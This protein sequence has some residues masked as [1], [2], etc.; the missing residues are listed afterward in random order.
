MSTNFIDEYLIKLGAAVD[1]SGM[2]RFHQALR[3][4]SAVAESSAASIAGAF[5]KAQTEV[6]S[7]LAA[8]G[9]A[10]LGLVDKVAMADQQYRLFALHMYMSKDA[11]RGL[12]VAMDALGEP[13]ENLAWDAELRA[14][15]HQL[16]LDQQAMAPNGDFD[17]QMRKIRDVRFEFTRMEVELQYLGMHV[18]QDF[19]KALGLGPDEL[20]AKLRGFNDWVTHHLPQISAT[21]VRDFMPVWKDLKD[22]FFAV[23]DALEATGTAFTNLV[24]LLTGDTAIEGSTFKLENFFKA[25]THI[26]H[27]FAVFAE[28]IANIEALLAHF[29]A[30]IVDVAAGNFSA[31]NAELAAAGADLRAKA[32]GAIVGGVTGGI[33][34]SSLGPLGTAG[35]AVGGAALGANIFDKA[36]GSPVNAASAGGA[37]SDLVSRYAAQY[38]VDPKLAHALMMQESSGN[39]SAVSS[40]GA[41][42]LMQL[43]RHTARALGVDRTNTDQNVEGGVRLFSQLL[44]KYHDPALAIAAYHDGEPRVDAFLARRATL[45][46]EALGEIAGVQ[47]RMN[48]GG[49]DVTVG[50]IVVH[51]DKPNAVN[52][53][54]GNA[55]AARLRG[56][57]DKRTQRNLSE[58][59][60]LSWG[61]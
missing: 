33:L 51:V 7:G 30:A 14:R 6:V 26:I 44:Q 39:P 3:E 55:V 12:K 56:L 10:A 41:V 49:G 59:Q 52:A 24:G 17:A 22:V 61:Y 34:G 42:G 60:G 13:L 48:A 38:G 37:A 31:A 40:T 32:V 47:R 9:G 28:A 53:D 1:A 36:F 23:K 19:M 8:I 46:S 5:F 35:G 50:S 58:F 2:A 11:A 16:I 18:V 27:G 29:T 45:S 4:A 21:I 20:L 15:T 57:Q 43:T 25:V 54:V